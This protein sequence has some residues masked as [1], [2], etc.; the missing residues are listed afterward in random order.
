MGATAAVQTQYMYEPFGSTTI[1]GPATTNSFAYASR[2]NDGTGLYFYRARY[3]HPTLQRFIAEDPI[4]LNGGP[5]LYAYAGNNP[6][7]FA[8]PLGLKPRP[9][10]WP[11]W[12]P[13]LWGPPPTPP[14]ESP[15]PQPP[16]PNPCGSHG[17]GFGVLGGGT[18][19]AGVA[20]AG[21]AATGSLGGGAF[22][23]S[24]SGASL[25]GFA[26]G[27]MAAYAGSAVTGDP[28]QDDGP[29]VLGAFAGAGVGVFVS[30]AGSAQQLAGH[31][32]TFSG[33]VGFPLPG[34]ISLQVSFSSNGTW[35]GSIAYGLGAGIGGSAVTTNTVPT[36]APCP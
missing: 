26:E 28:V 1:S 23:N 9:R 35:I 29:S 25:G 27:G 30:N 2:E 8:D 33:D 4:G 17:L 10:W 11:G 7:G 16:K 22:Y 19:E 20:V 15:Q 31:F 14:N 6:I 13:W 18:A 36:G 3:Y 34:K 5:N 21:A 24:S 32:L 12:L